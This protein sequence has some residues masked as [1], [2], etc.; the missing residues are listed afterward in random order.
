MMQRAKIVAVMTLLAA[1]LATRASAQG[2]LEVLAKTTPEERARIQTAFMTK[3]L[4]LSEAERGTIEAINLKYAQQAQPIITGSEGPFMKMR[5]MK[6]LDSA[7]DNELKGALTASQYQAYLA[8]KEEL[9]SHLIESL[10]N[11]KAAP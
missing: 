3:K 10:K 9:R 4:G 7:K 11:R 8:A 1:C 5:S 2:D 6:E